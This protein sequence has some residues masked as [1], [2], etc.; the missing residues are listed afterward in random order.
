MGG[1]VQLFGWS[2]TA[3]RSSRR[4]LRLINT[5]ALGKNSA[6]LCSALATHMNGQVHGTVRRTS[7]PAQSFPSLTSVPV[8]AALHSLAP[9]HLATNPTLNL[10]RPRW[11]SRR[12]QNESLE[13]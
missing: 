3:C 9:A 6:R 13:G 12:F 5:I 4:H 2:V 8:Q 10:C 1:K 7:I 11:I